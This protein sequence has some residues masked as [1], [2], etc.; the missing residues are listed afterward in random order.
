MRVG[1]GKGSILL[2]TAFEFAGLL[3]ALFLVGLDL[4]IPVQMLLVYMAGSMR[5]YGASVNF[6][7]CNMVLG[8]DFTVFLVGF[9]A[10]PSALIGVVS[11][12]G[13]FSSFNTPTQDSPEGGIAVA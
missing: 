2:I 1:L 13:I 12:A 9:P 7:L 11:I 8:I 5:G 3:L 4:W 10:W 6:I